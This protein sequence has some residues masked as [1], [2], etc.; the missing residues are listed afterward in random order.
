MEENPIIQ[1]EQST[2]PTLQPESA[3]TNVAPAP[4]ES[5]PM[6]EQAQTVE[7]VQQPELTPEEK[8]AKQKEALK[9]AG[10]ALGILYLAALCGIVAYAALTGGEELVIFNYLPVSQAKF[11]NFLFTVFNILFGGITI[12][13]IGIALFGLIKGLL[14]KQEEPDKKKKGM[15]I[16]IFGGIGVVLLA[17]LWLGAIWFLGPKLVSEIKSGI[18]TIPE[19]VIG[20]TAPTEVVFD[21]SYIPIDTDQYEILSYTWSFGDGDTSNGKTVS[22]RYIHKGNADGRYTVTLKVEFRDA[23]GQQY[24]SEYAVEVSISNELVAASFVASP[25]SGEV[26]LKV[27]FDASN[28]YDPD[29][30]IVSYEWDLDGDGNYDDAVG[31]TTEH[32]YTQEGSFEAG[33]KVTDNNGES[34]TTSQTI[35]AGSVNGLRAVINSNVV[36]GDYYYVGEKYDFSGELSQV[37]TGNI[38]KYEWDFGDGEKTQSRSASHTYEEAG[39]YTVTLTVTDSEG[40]KDSGELK[41]EVLEEGAPPTASIK[42]SDTSGSVPLNVDFD[43]SSSVDADSDIVQYQW[44]FDNDGTFD[45]SGD[46]VSYTYQEVGVYEARLVVTDATGN[47][48]EEIVQINVS[49]QGV[50][51][52]LEV[53]TTNGE[54]PVTVQFDASASS[55]K[56]GDIVSYTYDFGDGNTYTGGS[57]VTYKYRSIGTFNASVAILA[58][59]GKTATDSVQIVV[60]PVSL[61]ACF[62]VNNSSG[63]APLYLSVDPSCSTGTIKSYEWSFGDGDVSFD[64]KPEVHA[65]TTAGTYTVTLEVTGDNGIV[66]SFS[67]TITVR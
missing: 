16:A 37:R 44:D 15:R 3:V 26:P 61:T 49:A 41:I 14:A 60:R 58:D 2:E 7:P 62:T 43:G 54:V 38:T 50:S 42:A 31:A 46:K 28:S 4:I 21:A 19:N 40:N 6:P 32:E 20:L 48:D 51:A 23:A 29:G 35:E 67:N 52:V 25:S 66:D 45:D 53:S 56:D 55:Y 34:N 1:P 39:N 30:E 63:S 10:M 64:R 18:V 65:Y 22:H 9:R 47:E 57:S 24:S 59:D 36:T 11:G 13:A 33:L 5:M 12:A 8:K 17:V 27:K